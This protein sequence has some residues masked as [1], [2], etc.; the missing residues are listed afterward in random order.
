MEIPETR[1][2]CFQLIC[3][4]KQLSVYG[5]VTDWVCQFG[6]TDEEKRRVNLPMNEWNALR[7]EPE[8]VEMLVSSTP[9]QVSGNRMQGNASF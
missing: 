7:V 1:N 2:S 4:V 3:S 5:A 6:L 9:T 8:E